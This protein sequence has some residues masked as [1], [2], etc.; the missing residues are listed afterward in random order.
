MPGPPHHHSVPRSVVTRSGQAAR[1]RSEA[2]PLSLASKRHLSFYEVS[3]APRPAVPSLLTLSK[4][5]S[6][7]MGTRSQNFKD[8]KVMSPAV[9]RKLPMFPVDLKTRDCFRSGRP[10]NPHC[11]PSRGAVQIVSV[12]FGIPPVRTLLMSISTTHVS[13]CSPLLLLVRLT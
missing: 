4:L 6:P 9:G 3:R 2:K 5:V 1:R 10:P 8:Q 11:G 7:I 12:L 13:C